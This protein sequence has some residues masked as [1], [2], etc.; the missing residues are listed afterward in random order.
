M[1]RRR[2]SPVTLGA[3]C[4]LAVGVIVL[5]GIGGRMLAAALHG[6][7]LSSLDVDIRHWLSSAPVLGVASIWANRTSGRACQRLDEREA[8]V[9]GNAPT[10]RR[11]GSLIDA[12]DVVVRVNPAGLRSPHHSIEHRGRRAHMLHLNSN[13]PASRVAAVFDRFDPACVWTRG[14]AETAIQLGLR[15]ADVRID[16]YDPYQMV[17]DYPELA[18]CGRVTERF[19]TA[20]MLAVLHAL[21]L[22]AR[23]PLRVAGITAFAAAGHAITNYTKFHTTMLARHHCI[24]VERRLLR[25]LVR[26]GVV[27]VVDDA[28]SLLS[29]SRPQR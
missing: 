16:E 27:T 12:V 2:Q 26:E 14:R 8:I 24:D 4:C 28:A 9:V 13:H 1:A 19:L 21:H 22:G 23:R 7:W 5:L 18:E 10:V 29:S 25:R 15:Y 11:L 17:S 20:G 3:A 6:A